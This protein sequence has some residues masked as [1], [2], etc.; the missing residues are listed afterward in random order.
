MRSATI[1]LN[2]I[3]GLLSK[4]VTGEPRDTESGHAWFGGGR[5]EKCLHKR[6]SLVAYPTLWGGGSQRYK[7]KSCDTLQPK[8][9][10]NREYKADLSIGGVLSTR[11]GWPLLL[12]LANTVG[13]ST[14]E[15]HHSLKPL[16]SVQLSI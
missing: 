1:D 5:L 16:S 15:K 6:N 9:K 13:K 12:L 4:S 10:S 3:R 8:G 2:I 14:R 11:L 7:V